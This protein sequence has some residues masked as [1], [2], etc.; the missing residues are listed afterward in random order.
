[1]IIPRPRELAL[2]GG[3]SLPA[4][5]SEPRCRHDPALGPE[6][7]R[8]AVGPDG[9]D[10]AYGGPAGRFYGRR[11]LD[12]FGAAVP[13]GTI[14]DRPRFAWR[15]LM[16]DVARHFMPKP[17]VL[18]LIDLLAAHR[19]NVL[20]LHLTDDQGWRLEI[21]R[22]PRLTE[23][24]GERG[25]FYTHEDIHE[26]VSYAA[27]RHI[28]VVPEIDMPGHVQ[29][30]IAAY[31]HLGN[32]PERRLPV[33]SQ[34]GISDHV[35]NLEES[36]VAFFREVLDEVAELFPGPY[37]HVGGDECRPGEWLASPRSM[38][39]IAELGL[40]GA[41]AAAS[42]FLGRMAEHLT[43]R[44]KRTAY[45][46]EKPGGPPGSLAMTWL[47]EEAGARALD[48]GHDVVLTPHLRTY[49]DY[50]LA[51]E[52]GPFADG[53]VLALADTYGFD[54]DARALGVQCQLWTEYLPTPGD[55][56]A[57]AFPRLPAFAE[58]AW[59]STGDYG[60]FLE[61]LG[62]HLE[63]LGLGDTSLGGLTTK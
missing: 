50:P 41:E 54:P 15:G 24:G 37:V 63:S 13:Y 40:P 28:S 2:D 36:T 22:H 43:A 26:I 61:R 25:G 53:R 62:P 17:F 59:G 6:G 58:V 1:M 3:A 56:L 10:L 20:H 27:D 34:W 7:Y 38:A 4:A 35:L 9:V 12:R 51:A 8:L 39:R 18:R 45:W 11:T 14:E 33:W 60:D 16:L 30:A 52:P 42:W 21:K 23:V 32:F 19:L 57:A 49:F 29:A 31:P 48:E 46:Y 55:V 5:L 44:G 47:D